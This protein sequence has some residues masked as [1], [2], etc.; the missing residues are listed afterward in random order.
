MVGFVE[1]L[2]CADEAG[3]PPAVL[4]ASFFAHPQTRTKATATGRNLIVCLLPNFNPSPLIVEVVQVRRHVD[5][6]PKKGHTLGL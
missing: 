5:L 2:V 4:G 1:A 3:D 6:F